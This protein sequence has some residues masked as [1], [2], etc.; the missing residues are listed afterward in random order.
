[1]LPINVGEM[2]L[3]TLRDGEFLATVV[4]YLGPFTLLHRGK[5]AGY[6]V[7]TK[8]GHVVYEGPLPI[9]YGLTDDRKYW[10][11]ALDD[12]GNYRWM[13]DPELSA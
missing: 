1:M 7:R 4:E 8:F 5:D 13:F 11:V 3:I 6:L 10:Y 9:A 2:T 12:E